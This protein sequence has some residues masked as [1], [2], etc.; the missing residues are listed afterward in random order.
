MKFNP[1]RFQLLALPET[2]RYIPAPARIT[3]AL[4]RLEPLAPDVASR[5][6]DHLPMYA[7][8]Y[9]ER[10]QDD[11]PQLETGWK[12]LYAALACAWERKDYASVVA[13]VA[14]M[15]RPA[16]RICSLAEA[17]HLLWMGIEASRCVQDNQRCAYFLNRLG[18]LL[19]T[20][21]SYWFGRQ[22]W[23]ASLQLAA[24][25]TATFGL[26]QPLAS[27]AHIAD[28]LGSY[29]YAKQFVEAILNARHVDEPDSLAVAL[30]VRGFYARLLQDFDDA[31]EDLR[32][33]LQILSD[34]LTA[35]TA[36]PDQRLFTLVVQTELARVE[37]D[38][39][40][41]HARAEA[42]L[43]LAQVYSDHHTIAALLFDQGL[44]AH[45]QGRFADIPPIF[46][47]LRALA[48]QMNTP[49][50][51][52]CCQFLGQ[53]AIEHVQVTHPALAMAPSIVTMARHELLSE[54]ERQVLNFVAAGYTNREIAARLVIERATVKKHL[55][56]IFIKLDV[57][58]RTSAI[59]KARA[60]KVI[61]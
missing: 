38:Y 10:Y 41:A 21:A 26:W 37:G 31:R 54:R 51:H 61:P 46:L 36:S 14:G 27:F 56:H 58:N 1:L 34:R 44:Y 39:T 7:L 16:G 12:V 59:A 22:I 42:A 28:I 32:C 5:D 3:D 55:E 24:S 53:Y 4:K 18:G 47:H 19:F 9:I 11:V 13:L 35:N 30:F 57:H 60:L 45:A 52:S 29:S 33:C 23:S 40:H 48:R 20:H 6:M 43:A 17:E 2:G 8:K 15:A 49:H 25:S 50:I